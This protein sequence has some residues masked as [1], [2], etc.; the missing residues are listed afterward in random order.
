MFSIM[1]FV[2]EKI[3]KEKKLLEIVIKERNLN[4]EKIR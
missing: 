4:S 1:E 2:C 3:E